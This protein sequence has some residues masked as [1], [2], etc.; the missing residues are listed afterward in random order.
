MLYTD[1]TSKQGWYPRGIA[2]YADPV[3]RAK[4]FKHPSDETIG[5]KEHWGPYPCTDKGHRDEWISVVKFDDGL[6]KI[7]YVP[8]AA[9][10]IKLDMDAFYAQVEKLPMQTPYQTSKSYVTKYAQASVREEELSR[11]AKML[12]KMNASPEYIQ[13]V[14]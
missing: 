11:I 13:E 1:D 10:E 9:I 4:H 5:I 7:F 3:L 8:C 2:D 12:E 14:I 6:Q